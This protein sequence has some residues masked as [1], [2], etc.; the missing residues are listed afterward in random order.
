M[1]KQIRPNRRNFVAI[2]GLAVLS[3]AALWLD[4]AAAEPAADVAALEAKGVKFKRAQDGTIEELHVGPDALLTLDD[5]RVLGR[6]RDTLRRVSLCAKEP[7]LNGA[8]LA[9]VGPLPK[10]EQ[11]FSNGARLLDD[12]FKHFAGW[13][14]LRRFG[15]D[16]WGWFETPDKKFVGP[17]LAHLAVL[18]HLDWLR[19]GG[20]RIGNPAV[21]ALAKIKSLQ[22]VDLFHD[23]I[24]DEGI[25]DLRSLPDLRVIKLGPQFTPRITD[26]SLEHLSA[27]PTLEEIHFSETWLTYAKGFVHLK[28]VPRLRAVALVKVLATADDVAKLKAD[29]PRA[30]IQWTEPDAATGKKM[31]AAFERHWKRQEKE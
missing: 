12:D 22:Y 21:E 10:V 26:A 9:A 2:G 29:H 1:T 24:T 4:R 13:T 19:L 3:P 5:Y 8:V 30:E 16:H 25:P 17:G 18:P 27:I 23:Q 14:G 31:K 6:Y 11:F 7:A 15:L 28:R 20:C